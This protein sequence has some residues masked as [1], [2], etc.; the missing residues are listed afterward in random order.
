MYEYVSMERNI[1]RDVEQKFFAFL[2]LQ[3]KNTI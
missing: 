1:G 2:F 3:F